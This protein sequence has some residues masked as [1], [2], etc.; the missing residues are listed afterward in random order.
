MQCYIHAHK[1][2]VDN[3]LAKLGL[4][5]LYEKDESWD[6]L[7]RFLETLVQESYDE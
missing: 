6:K 4:R 2:Q 7:G 5:K 3:K 1:L